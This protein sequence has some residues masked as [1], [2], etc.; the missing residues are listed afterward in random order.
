MDPNFGSWVWFYLPDA[1]TW[2]FCLSRVLLP[3]QAAG[4]T[5]GA[6]FGSAWNYTSYQALHSGVVSSHHAVSCW[7]RAWKSGQQIFWETI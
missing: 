1:L 5:C 4:F 7:R 2:Q 3:N 6:E